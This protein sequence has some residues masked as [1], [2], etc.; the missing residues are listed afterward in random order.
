MS[1]KV[2]DERDMANPN[3]GKGFIMHNVKSFIQEM[4]GGLLD[5]GTKRSLWPLTFGLACC[6]V[7]MMQAA[8]ARYDVLPTPP[9]LPP[10]APPFS[11]IPYAP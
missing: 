1:L 4:A 5:W 11:R 9:R 6:A 2:I 10:A 3:E 8:A 7:E